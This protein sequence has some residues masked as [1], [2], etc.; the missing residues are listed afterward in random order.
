LSTI[1]EGAGPHSGDF[2]RISVQDVSRH[3]GR[4]RALSR[5]SLD[6]WAGEI[7]GLLGPNGAGK[8]TLLGI[9]GTLVAPSSGRVIY[10]TRTA[11]EAGPALRREIGVL[12]H[13]PSLY[14]ELTARENL[15]FFGR[16]Y[17]LAHAPE[18]A[19]EALRHAGL[20]SRA[21]EPVGRFSRGMR[22]RIA[23]ERAL[24]HDPRLILLDE[25]FAGLDDRSSGAL[26]ERLRDLAGGGR[27]VLMAT[28]DLELVSGVLNRAAILDEGRLVSV[29]ESGGSW[30][31]V[32]RRSVKD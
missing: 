27:I 18:R 30:T 17:G 16:A 22:Q 7:F 3:F 2:D 13:E 15:E 29:E 21:D 26:V 12:S 19:S 10:G 20:E 1:R 32:Y 14:P 4:R 31:P 6:V 9:L 5:V 8:S 25:P 28:H 23:L 24:I 11:H